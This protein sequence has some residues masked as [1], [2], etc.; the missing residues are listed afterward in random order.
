MLF[1]KNKILLL[2]LISLI[3][4]AIFGFFISFF[5]ANFYIDTNFWLR[6]NPIEALPVSNDPNM[7]IACGKPLTEYFFGFP[8]AFFQGN[9]ERDGGCGMGYYINFVGLALNFIFYWILGRLIFG[10]K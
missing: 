6:I 4:F 5:F 8:F 1:K 9:N 10:K 7:I 3:I 2:S